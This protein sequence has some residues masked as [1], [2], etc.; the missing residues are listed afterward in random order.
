MGTRRYALEITAPLT[1]RFKMRLER[2]VTH[3]IL[4]PTRALPTLR[5]AVLS[6]TAQLRAQGVRDEEIRAIFT[7]LIEDVARDKAIDAT[8]IVSGHP[9]WFDLAARVLVWTETSGGPVDH[10]EPPERSQG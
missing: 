8:S 1:R 10:D 2:A 7:R 3:A 9:R 6:A 4:N 5:R